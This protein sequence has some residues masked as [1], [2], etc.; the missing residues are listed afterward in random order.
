MPRKV[1]RKKSLSKCVLWGDVSGC[2]CMRD[3]DSERRYGARSWIWGKITLKPS[4]SVISQ[5]KEE[6]SQLQ[7]ELKE[8]KRRLSVVVFN[9]ELLENELKLVPLPLWHGLFSVHSIFC[10]QRQHVM[11]VAHISLLFRHRDL[12]AAT[13]EAH[14]IAEAYGF[15]D[16]QEHVEGRKG[17]EVATRRA[18]IDTKEEEIV[19]G[20]EYAA[21][22]RSKAGNIGDGHYNPAVRG[23]C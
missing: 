13:G 3:C 17:S 4:D 2:V 22:A 15:P 18:G 10:A 1:E 23:S 9:K 5:A 20:K 7:T 11:H 8:K 16:L 19:A 12:Q 14:R 21:Q 6:I